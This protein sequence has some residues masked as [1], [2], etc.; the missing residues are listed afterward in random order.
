M[1]GRTPDYVNVTFAGFAG[2]PGIWKQA[3]ND[4][5][6]ENL[7]AFQREAAER[8]CGKDNSVKHQFERHDYRNQAAPRYGTVGTE[9]K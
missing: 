4:Q 6:Y 3:G 1:L 5:G 2:Q 8:D 7:I 9:C